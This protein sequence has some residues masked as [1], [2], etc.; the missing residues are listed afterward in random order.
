MSEL[1]IF[2]DRKNA[3]NRAFR[4]GKTYDFNNLSQRDVAELLNALEGEL[5]PENLCCDGELSGEP[6]RRKAR[7]LNGAKAELETLK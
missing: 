2:I 3:M 7:H 4:V 6:L 5:S 1:K